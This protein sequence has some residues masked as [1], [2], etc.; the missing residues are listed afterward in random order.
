MK[1]WIAEGKKG[2]K[3]NREIRAKEIARMLY[4]DDREIS[5]YKD[6]LNK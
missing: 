1:D 4:F 5:I 3:I 2:Q 6:N